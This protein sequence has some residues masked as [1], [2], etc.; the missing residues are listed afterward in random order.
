MSLVTL[1]ENP[2]TSKFTFPIVLISLGTLINI[3]YANT[4][5]FVFDATNS[6]YG[7]RPFMLIFIILSIV[8]VGL[9]CYPQNRKAINYALYILLTLVFFSLASFILFSISSQMYFNQNSFSFSSRDNLINDTELGL[10]I[11][12]IVY[13]IALILTFKTSKKIK[14]RTIIHISF[15]VAIIVNIISIFLPSVTLYDSFNDITQYNPTIDSPIAFSL[16]LTSIIFSISALRLFS[17]SNGINKQKKL[18]EKA[19]NQQIISSITNGLSILLYIEYYQNQE[20]LN[21]LQNQIYLGPAPFALL[22]ALIINIIP[23]M[24]IQKIISEL[25]E[26]Q[27]LEQNRICSKCNFKNMIKSSFC[28]SCGSKLLLERPFIKTSKN[29]EENK[30]Q[31]SLD[32]NFSQL[33]PPIKSQSTNNTTI[34]IILLLSGLLCNFI[35]FISPYAM[36]NYYSINYY[37]LSDPIGSLFLLGSIIFSILAFFLLTNTKSVNISNVKKIQLVSFL[38]NGIAIIIYFLDF[39][40]LVSNVD[41][42]SFNPEVFISVGMFTLFLACLINFIAFISINR[43]TLSNFSAKY[44]TIKPIHQIFTN[45]SIICPQ[46]RNQNDES[47]YFCHICGFNLVRKNK[48][49]KSVNSFNSEE[50]E[51]KDETIPI[52]RGSVDSTNFNPTTQTGSSSPSKESILPKEIADQAPEES[53]IIS[54]TNIS[55]DNRP[56]SE[57]ELLILTIL[58]KYRKLNSLFLANKLGMSK[59]KIEEIMVLLRKKEENLG[60]EDNLEFITLFY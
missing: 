46:C 33:A 29:H 14:R 2:K 12:F 55:K 47:N 52:A 42:H 4:Y 13:L 28:G 20:R 59:D 35:S 34:S 18:F 54:E 26:E 6:N 50:I 51:D 58:R 17:K 3:Y 31:K 49:L 43:L 45:N 8:S 48:N 27:K 57:I 22:L 40:S 23:I 9:L 16:L 44:S 56:F 25:N 10:L 38:S 32:N 21:S 1:I 24:T 41:G 30:S 19:R 11:T 39:Q 53:E 37:V 15:I 5:F 7:I 36:D 60:I